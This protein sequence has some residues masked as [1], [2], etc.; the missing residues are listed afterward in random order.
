MRPVT[1][2]HFT[3]HLTKLVTNFIASS[4]TCT[5]E[6]LTQKRAFLAIHCLEHF[7]AKHNK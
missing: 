2:Y 6:T 3:G 4:L 7:H 1:S 5:L